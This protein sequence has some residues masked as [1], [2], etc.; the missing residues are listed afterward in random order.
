M[1]YAVCTLFEGNYHF[2][3][4]AL[5]NSLYKKGFRGSIYAGYRGQLPEWSNT[6]KSTTSFQWEG[7]KTLEVGEGMQIHFL[8]LDTDYHFSNHK[9]EFMLRLFEGPAKDAEGLCYFD[10]DIVVKCEWKF[11]EYWL[12]FGVAL[13]HEVI[14]NDMHA[15]HPIR[16]GWEQ[17]IKNSNREVT[18]NILSYINGGFCGLTKANIEFLKVWS[19]FIELAISDFGHHR[20]DFSGMARSNLF[21]C[22][23]QDA[24]NIAAMCSGTP[25]SEL[26]AD[27]MDFVNGG[28]TMSHATGRPKPWNKKFISSF[29][30]GNS[31]SKA[32]HCYWM[33]VVYPLAPY[34]SKRNVIFKLYCLKIASFLGRFYRRY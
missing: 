17:L 29:L 19:E 30:S 23:D 13:V 15:T 4:A 5:S 12:S 8:P 27:G 3:V 31:P 33:N 28:W 9:P 18:S 11:F 20:S 6:A 22:A 32:D 7:S 24:I 16:K 21:Y 10:P 34:K 2:G 1:S 14:S 25:I 26:G